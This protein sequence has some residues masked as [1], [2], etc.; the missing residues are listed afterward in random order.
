[1]K[2]IINNPHL[3]QLTCESR[4]NYASS[5]L[6]KTTRI[7]NRSETSALNLNLR[8]NKQ[9]MQFISNLMDMKQC[10]WDRCKRKDKKL[11]KCNGCK[12]MLYCSRLCQKRHWK[13][14]HRY[15]CSGCK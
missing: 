7:A 12:Q 6:K 11:Y 14:S 9:M 15:S 3:K 8:K 2:N 10:R 1:M 5:I 13:N 4:W